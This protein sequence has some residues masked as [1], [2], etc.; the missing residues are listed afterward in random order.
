M[1]ILTAATVIIALPN[2]FYGM[3]GMNLPLPFH[4]DFALNPLPYISILVFTIILMVIIYLIG[5]HRR[6]F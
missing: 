1:Q 2:V 3:F 4:K 6:F 5:K